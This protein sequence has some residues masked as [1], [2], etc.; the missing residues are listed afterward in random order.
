MTFRDLFVNLYTKLY[1]NFIYFFKCFDPNRNPAYQCEEEE[2]E[3][4][5]GASPY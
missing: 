5:V 4:L 1:T 2:K 3:E